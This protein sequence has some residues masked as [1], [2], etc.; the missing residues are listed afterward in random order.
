MELTVEEKIDHLKNY[1]HWMAFST[2]QQ[3]FLLF[4]AQGQKATDAYLKAYPD[5]NP[6]ST[7]FQLIAMMKQHRMRAALKLLGYESEDTDIVGRKEALLLMSRA[8]RN[9]SL[10]PEMLV[11]I[12][13]VYAKMRGWDKEEKA[14]PD[15]AVSMDKLVAAVEKKRKDGG[16]P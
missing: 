14:P 2:Q 11:K 5:R 4:V 6:K 8:L 3:N 13:N 10:D 12:M 7:S 16:T 15:D 1:Q 9:R